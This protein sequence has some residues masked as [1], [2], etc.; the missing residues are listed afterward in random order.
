MR[1]VICSFSSAKFAIKPL[2][3]PCLRNTCNQKSQGLR[4]D[5]LE[6]QAVGKW[7]LLVQWLSKSFLSICITGLVICGG[8]SSGM[9]F[10]LSRHARCWNAGITWLHKKLS[11]RS[12]LTVQ[13]TGPISSKKNSPIVGDVVKPHLCRMKCDWFTCEW[14]FR[15][16]YLSILH[17]DKALE[18]EIDFV[19]LQ[20]ISWP[21]IVHFCVSKEFWSK[22]VSCYQ[23]SRKQFLNMDNFVRK[24]MQDVR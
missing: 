1:S 23:M 12:Q 4:T 19:C 3:T 11:Y 17:I 20:N 10:I 15:S 9:K 24:A 5:D 7:R 22:S 2:N 13:V 18:T 16:P 8:E 14:L 21:F 6:W